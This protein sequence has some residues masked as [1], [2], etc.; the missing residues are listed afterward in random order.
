MEQQEFDL[1]K[2]I[3]SHIQHGSLRPYLSLDLS[4][5]AHKLLEQDRG[6]PMLISGQIKVNDGSLNKE[7]YDDIVRDKEN[8]K[9]LNSS[10]DSIGISAIMIND[11]FIKYGILLRDIVNFPQDIPESMFN[12]SINLEK[13]FIEHFNCFRRANGKSELKRNAKLPTNLDE[14]KESDSHIRYMKFIFEED[15]TF[16]Q[17][18]ASCLIN[19]DFIDF[20]AMDICN[21]I[22]VKVERDQKN[23]S[24]V[25][26]IVLKKF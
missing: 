8:V 25:L 14:I 23:H 12:P 16:C 5:E 26:I 21:A 17:I 10:F 6:D 11:S 19:K 1:Y 20:I 7:I 4:N 9:L 2:Y 24:L 22:N 18:M 13:C 3:I 15:E